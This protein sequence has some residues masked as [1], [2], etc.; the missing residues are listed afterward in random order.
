MKSIADFIDPLKAP[1]RPP[2]RSL[3]SFFGWSL[4]G[5]FPALS[6]SAAV[7][8]L[9]GFLEVANAVILGHLIDKAISTGPD[10]FFDTHLWFSIGVFAFFMVLR[11]LVL[12]ASSVINFVLIAPNIVLMVLMRLHRWTLGQTSGFFDSELTGRIAQKQL[13][14][15]RALASFAS[16]TIYLVFYALVSFLGAAFLL[17]SVSWSIALLLAGWLVV[18]LAL[19]AWYMPKLRERSAHRANAYSVL[20]GSIV[21]TLSNMKTVTLFARGQ[22]E[23]ERA[24]SVATS[25]RASAI[26]WGTT[27]AWFRFLL[28]VLAGSLPV[29]LIGSSVLLWADGLASEGDIAAAGAI[30]IRVA[31]MTGYISH[32]LMGL[33]ASLGE[34]E[35]GIA[36]L[37]RP[38]ALPDAES[39]APLRDPHPVIRFENVSFSYSGSS[40]QGV[41]DINLTIQPGEKVGI[42]GPSGAGKSTLLALI[43]RM[44]DPVKGRVLV[45]DMDVRDMEQESLRRNICGVLQETAI[46]SRSVRENILYGQL[47]ATDEDIIYAARGADAHDFIMQLEDG[48]GREGYD[49]LLGERG[50]TLSGGQRQRISIARALLTDAPIVLLDEATSALDSET[51]ATVQNAI[52]GKLLDR[53]VLVVAHRLSTVMQMDRIIVLDAGRIVEQ[54]THSQLLFKGGLYARFWARQREQMDP[55][56][57][58]QERSV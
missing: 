40:D 50:A 39:A 55:A 23:V 21:D 17:V 46:F 31:Q 29:L 47:D 36:L 8:T 57:M 43:L 5:A 45:G 56:N 53:T 2:P 11:P 32:T 18:Y 44:I 1:D 35:D 37:T 58:M 7:W 51:D 49:A 20:T 6:L 9:A 12:G 10:R 28:T 13:Q 30:A 22:H 19:I 26:V 41:Q 14:T 52:N 24:G 15:S 16:E 54:G 25:Y 42:V 48:F 3:F 34:I 4:K 27:A 33:H 38:H